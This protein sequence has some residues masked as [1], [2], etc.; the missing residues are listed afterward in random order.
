MTGVQTCALPICHA[1]EP[2][3]DP[4]QRAEAHKR[5]RRPRRKQ[6][7]PLGREHGPRH[8]ELDLGWVIAAGKNPLDYFN[9][10]P[11]RFPLWHLKDMDVVKKHSVEFGKGSLNIKQ[12]FHNAKKSGMKYFFIEQEEYTNNP[13]ES[14]Q[15]NMDYL[16]KL[17]L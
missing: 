8:M 15:M 11:G 5:R 6:G 7:R 16:K 9:K 14:M 2:T 13:F 1:D 17:K 3:G 12:M 4:L 10:Y